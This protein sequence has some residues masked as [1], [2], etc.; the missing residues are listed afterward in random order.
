MPI[1]NRGRQL[2]VQLPFLAAEMGKR[3]TDVT[4]ALIGGVVDRNDGIFFRGALPGEGQKAIV[5]PVTVPA[6]GALQKL[7]L[8]DTKDWLAQ[9]FEKPVVEGLQVLV[10]RLARAARKV[11]RNPLETTLELALVEEAQPRCKEGDDGG[12]LVDGQRKRCR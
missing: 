9:G 8:A 7:P 4:L 11:G 3:Q 10:D 2:V 5:A 12:G 6:G 1:V